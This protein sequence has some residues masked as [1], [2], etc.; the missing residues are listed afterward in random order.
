MIQASMQTGQ[1]LDKQDMV[2]DARDVPLAPDMKRA[3]KG[4]NG[5]IQLLDTTNRV[6]RAPNE[7]QMS[8]KSGHNALWQSALASSGTGIETRHEPVKP[9]EKNFEVM[10]YGG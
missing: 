9:V 6:M 7:P 1:K 8:H 2:P 10:G 5:Q 4:Q 3:L